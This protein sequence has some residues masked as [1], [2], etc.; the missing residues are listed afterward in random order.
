MTQGERTVNGVRLRPVLA[1]WWDLYMMAASTR[2]AYETGVGEWIVSYTNPAMLTTSVI[3]TWHTLGDALQ[4]ARA[5]KA[6]LR[7]EAGL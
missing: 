7:D 5:H 1:Y 4:G 3:G 2:K 6:R